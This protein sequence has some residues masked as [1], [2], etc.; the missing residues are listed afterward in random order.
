MVRVCNIIIF[1][2]FIILTA[3]R[4]ESYESSFS[5]ALGRIR[6]LWTLTCY[7]GIYELG[8]FS[9]KVVDELFHLITKSITLQ[10]THSNEVIFLCKYY[11]LKVFIFA[12]VFVMLK[13]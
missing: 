12:T 1:F 9:I 4:S 2:F 7:M 6:P 11:N 3:S 10:L 13:R 8:I 5:I